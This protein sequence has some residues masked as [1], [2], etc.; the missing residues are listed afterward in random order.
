M[1]AILATH[2]PEVIGLTI[3]HSLWQVTLLWM[4]LVVAL[5]IWPQAAAP[6]R[7][8]LALGALAL[9]LT[10]AG[11][12]AWYEWQSLSP[13]SPEAITVDPFA[14]LAGAS[15]TTAAPNLLSTLLALADAY[16]PLLAWLWLTGITFMGIRFAGSFYYLKTLR[17]PA[18]LTP[19]GD[20]WQGE[21]DRLAK[22]IGLTQTIRVAESAR[23]SSPITL[24]TF[25]PLVLLPAGLVG[26]LTTAQIEAILVH[27]LYHIKRRDYAINVAQ[28]LVE[29]LM[30]YHPAIW[31]ICRIIREER[32]NCCDDKT[33]AFCGDPVPYARA[34]TQIHETNTLTKPPFAMSA[35]GPTGTFAARIKRLFNIYPNP[36]KARSKGLFALSLLLICFGLLLMSANTLPIVPPQPAKGIVITYQ[37]TTPLAA[38]TVK[39]DSVRF[40][41][42]PGHD[43]FTTAPALT[44]QPLY[45]VD[46][47][48]VTDGSGASNIKPEDIKSIDVLK[49]E[50]AKSLY[51][52]R[53]ADGVV[54]IHTSKDPAAQALA[55]PTPDGLTL[56]V[57]GY[58]DS[59]TYVVVDDKKPGIIMNYADKLAA[60]KSI[61][62]APTGYVPATVVKSTSIT[63]TS[64]VT[65]APQA[66]APLYIVNGIQRDHAV[67]ARI[68]PAN[69]Q[70]V[71]VF[72]NESAAVYGA[73]S[74]NGVIVVTLKPD[75]QTPLDI[76][77]APVQ[78][79]NV[80]TTADVDAS[81]QLYP[82]AAHEQATVVFTAPRNEAQIK[83]SVIDTQ[84]NVV[85]EVANGR[86]DAGKHEVTI[87]TREYKKGIY[88]VVVQIDDVKTQQRLS[89][90]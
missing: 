44:R 64:G 27:E 40:R 23:I 60:P 42:A 49:G 1:N 3:L 75:V 35:T 13:V 8:A 16:A 29:V 73:Q 54:L 80:T 19:M 88:I 17:D 26:G 72:K 55:P 39:K 48:E 32:E 67:L 38:D 70:T 84:G 11:A 10:G 77:V 12:T 65:A 71:Q 43:V 41:S 45:I 21:F 90:E 62:V 87:D 36:A 61:T 74:A 66:P 52:A 9:C 20:R 86:Y 30:F 89:V 22:A 31:Q 7:Y 83:V 53:G 46:G 25:S 85:R 28:A 4:L 59:T 58:R 34:L 14:L 2:L 68:D 33:L 63:S 15:T 76:A 50:S 79:I 51:G 47:K 78:K 57:V 5:R 24:G 69:I 81:V 56:S 6:L 82:N 37:K 18:A